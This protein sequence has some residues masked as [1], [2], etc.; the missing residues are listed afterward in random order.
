MSADSLFARIGGHPILYNFV[1]AISGRETVIDRLRPWLNTISGLVIDVGGGTGQ[2][3]AHLNGSTRYVCV[4][5][6]HAKMRGLNRRLLNGGAVLADAVALPIRVESADAVLCIG[7]S[8]HVDDASLHRVLHEIASV[9]TPTGQL[10]FLDAVWAPRRL[11]GRALWAVDRGS[12]PRTAARIA[13][14]VDRHFEIEDE[15]TFVVLHEYCAFRCRKRHS[16]ANGPDR[17][18][19][20]SR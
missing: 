16:P 3:A 5:L 6:E 8:H 1:Q 20:G 11:A 12:Y 13:T 10:L 19:A 2:I 17:D 18:G 14:A 15:K 7:F 9:L 4:D